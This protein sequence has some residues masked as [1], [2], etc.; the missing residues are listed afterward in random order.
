MVLFNHELAEENTTLLAAS[1]FFIALKTLEQ[2][3][4]TVEPEKK[5]NNICRLLNV[6]EDEV[7]ELSR[8]VLD[9]A[10]NFDRIYPNLSNL[11]KFNKFEYNCE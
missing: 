2:V 5:I 1:V 10:K 6:L 3:D 8:K 7:L 9:L 11:K 4:S